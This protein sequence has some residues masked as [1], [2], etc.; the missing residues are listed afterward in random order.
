MT[1]TISEMMQGV[2]I[3]E[4]GVER[5]LKPC[6]RF[7]SITDETRDRWK[8][9]DHFTPINCDHKLFKLDDGISG[10][11][12][13][14]ATVDKS[15]CILNE[16][17]SHNSSGNIVVRCSEFLETEL[18]YLILSSGTKMK[19]LVPKYAVHPG[20][21]RVAKSYEIGNVQLVNEGLAVAGLCQLRNDSS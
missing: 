17:I 3:P 8:I 5:T 10:N 7:H 12:R 15:R 2:C 16:S 14:R 20:V 9:S 4:N 18:G 11:G 6:K 19:T 21:I 13:L 1:V